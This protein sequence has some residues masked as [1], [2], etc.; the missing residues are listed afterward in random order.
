[1]SYDASFWFAGILIL[2]GGVATC[3]VPTF[4]KQKNK[5]SDS[6]NSSI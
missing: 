5:I 4:E 2:F 6:R 3:L 1:M